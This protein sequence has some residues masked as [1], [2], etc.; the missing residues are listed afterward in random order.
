MTIFKSERD[1]SRKDCVLHGDCIFVKILLCKLVLNLFGNLQ[2]AALLARGRLPLSACCAD[3]C[4]CAAWNHFSEEQG[5][6][7][8]E[9][10]KTCWG[11]YFMQF[12]SKYVVFVDNGGKS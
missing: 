6:Q 11:L 2:K 9:E 7:I 10:Y 1:L 5:W 12:R 8:Q 3:G 4:T